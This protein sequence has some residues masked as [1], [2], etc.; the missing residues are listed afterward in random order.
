MKFIIVHDSIAVAIGDDLWV[1][2]RRVGLSDYLLGDGL[3]SG[4]FVGEGFRRSLDDFLYSG[5]QVTALLKH[6][7]HIVY[8]HATSTGHRQSYRSL[9][10]RVAGIRG[11]YLNNTTGGN[12]TDN[13][14]DISNIKS[15]SRF[16][17]RFGL[18]KFA[19]IHLFTNTLFVVQIL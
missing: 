6:K 9:T 17:K 10:V 5:V 14:L 12:Y 7:G 3:S 15:C 11:F 2:R 4:R 1:G 8:T 18:P 13:T 19:N 16:S